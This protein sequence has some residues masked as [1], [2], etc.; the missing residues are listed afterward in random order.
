MKSM[1]EPTFLILTALAAG[2]QHGYGVITDVERISDGQVRL[3]AGTLYA[4]FDRLQAEGLIE[5]DREEIVDGRVRRYYR[6]T[7]DGAARLAAEAERMSRH[8][9][10]AAARLRA[11]GAGGLA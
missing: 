8:A 6:L 11:A 7:G 9:R 2:P 4:A 3:R 5:A 10:A 1:Q